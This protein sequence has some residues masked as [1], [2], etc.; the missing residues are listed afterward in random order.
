MTIGPRLRAIRKSLHLKQAEFGKRIGLSQP[1]IGQYEKETRPITERVISQL[2]ENERE[3]AKLKSTL[4]IET[5][6]AEQLRKRLADK[7]K[8]LDEKKQ[9]L[10]EQAKIE[11]REIVEEAKEL[12]DKSIRDYNKWLKNPE[13]IDARTLEETRTTLRKKTESYGSSSNKKTERKFS[14]HKSTDFHIGDKVLV[15]SLEVEGHVLELPDKN[16]QVLVEMGILTSRY[17]IDDLLI[18]DEDKINTKSADKVFME[19]RGKSAGRSHLPKTSVSGVFSDSS[20]AMNFS[21]EI[22]LLGKTVDEAVAELDKFLDDALLTHA[23]TVRIVH[24]KGTGALRRGITEYLKKQRFVK[25]FRSGEFGEGD[26]GVT[27]VKL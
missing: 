4:E 6:S 7:E 15:L 27:I 24:G 14:G 3:M 5:R 13:K 16:N 25:E 23:G 10:I 1:T 20:K 2:E 21:P 18:I 9:Q 8:T 22:N 12:A 19:S 11:A 26:S 17:P